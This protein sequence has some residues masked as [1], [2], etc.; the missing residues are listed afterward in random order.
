M[1]ILL[2]GVPFGR[3]NIGDE[4][5]LACVLRIVRAAA[6]KA[7]ITV[8]TD[9]PATAERL[10]VDVCPLFGFDVVPYGAAEMRAVLAA[11]DIYLWSG[12]TGL[13]D[14][15]DR[16]CE[17]LAAARSAGCAR[18]VW[19]VG[20][21]NELNPAKYRLQGRRLAV[22]RA[23][24]RL[25]GGLVGW[26]KKQEA[27]LEAKARE[28][29]RRE[30]LDCA[31]L[32]TR[33]PESAREVA[34]CGVPTERVIVGADSALIEETTAWPPAALSPGDRERLEAPGRK[35]IG[36]CISAQR[37][38]T[39]RSELIGALNTLL[40]DPA[41][42]IV[43]LPMNPLT[44]LALLESLLPEIRRPEAFYPLRGITETA[45]MTALAARMD[46]LIS[47]RLHLLILGS[48]HHVPLIGISRGSKVD[49]FLAPFGLK[50]VGSVESCDFAALV[51]E[52]R[53]LLENRAAFGETSRQVRAD[54][55]ARLETARTKLA[56]TLQSLHPRP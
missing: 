41:V 9:D 56:S 6:P 52:T 40:E 19:N 53:R 24:D 17:I 23:V 12:A 22:T 31:L 50:A 46:V 43:G 16:A 27:A 11:H 4:A 2:G 13:S 1:N 10:G 26:Q 21:N 29:L 25:S 47:S 48:I 45:D 15:P 37:E 36:L 51:R 18:I 44:D 3:N 5:I 34:A 55:L 30:L 8:S 39:R 14:Y 35:R 28:G 54:L 38:I 49:N 20:M 33:D 42:E 32:V 7:R